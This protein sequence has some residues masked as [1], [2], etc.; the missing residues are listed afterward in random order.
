MEG[1]LIQEPGT[2]PDSAPATEE[3][4]RIRLWRFAQSRGLGLSHVEALLFAES[5]GD[6]GLFRGL[7]KKGCPAALALRIVL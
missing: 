3:E 2:A 7:V 5:G 4:R 6:L 1:N